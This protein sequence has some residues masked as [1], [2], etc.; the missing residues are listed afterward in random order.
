MTNN[1][2][3]KDQFIRDIRNYLN[4]LDT[5]S[6]IVPTSHITLIKLAEKYGKEKVRN[7]VDKQFKAQLK[8]LKKDS[9]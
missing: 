7:E 3:E 1:N 8:Q 5:Q 4:E 6:P 2:N 9:H